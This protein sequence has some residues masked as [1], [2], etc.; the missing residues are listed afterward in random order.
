[1]Y[2]INGF[3]AYVPKRDL[4]WLCVL[5]KT[6]CEWPY[7]SRAILNCVDKYG[8]Y[9]LMTKPQDCLFL[10]GKRNE[11]KVCSMCRECKSLFERKKLHQFLDRMYEIGQLK[12]CTRSVS[13]HLVKFMSKHGRK[14]FNRHQ[15]NRKCLV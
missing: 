4:R 5:M 12:S 11:E 7:K 3:E 6:I 1:M 14:L 10:R 13:I 2:T 9:L 8:G 15:L